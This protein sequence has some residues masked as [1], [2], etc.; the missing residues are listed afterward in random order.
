MNK[1]I[2]K[3]K[4]EKDALRNRMYLYRKTK[5]VK[6]FKDKFTVAQWEKISGDELVK[7]LAL[8]GRIKATKEGLIFIREIIKITVSKYKDS[9]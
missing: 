9:I 3:I 2:K 1:S 5:T 8:D 7:Y 6:A 4:K